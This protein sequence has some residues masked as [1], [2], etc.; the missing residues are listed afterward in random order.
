MSKRRRGVRHPT[1]HDFDETH[2]H[3]PAALL[4]ARRGGGLGSTDRAAVQALL[5]MAVDPSGEIQIVAGSRDQAAE[6]FR[7]AQALVAQGGLLEPRDVNEEGSDVR[8]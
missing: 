4:L 5:D 6:V 8:A 7:S 2:A 1:F 3:P